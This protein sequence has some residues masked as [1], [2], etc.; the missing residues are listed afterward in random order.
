MA[1]DVIMFDDVP[2]VVDVLTELQR[3]A[4]GLELHLDNIHVVQVVPVVRHVPELTAKHVFQ[5][6]LEHAA[7]ELKVTKDEFDASK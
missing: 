4:T 6:V 7:V 5:M 2:L 1:T 3:F